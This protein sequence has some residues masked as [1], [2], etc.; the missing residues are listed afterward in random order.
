MFISSKVRMPNCSWNTLFEFECGRESHI[1]Q[2]E[3]DRDALLEAYARIVPAQLDILPPEKRHRIYKMMNVSV[4]GHRD[5]SLEIT[6]AYDGGQS[7][8]SNGEATLPGSCR[9]RGR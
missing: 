5:S 2:L 3:C 1:K 7:H 9:T 4:L 8:R 6:W